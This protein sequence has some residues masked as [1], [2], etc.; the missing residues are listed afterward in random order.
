M[1]RVKRDDVDDD[2]GDDGTGR[3]RLEDRILFLLFSIC[4]ELFSFPPL[5]L[6]NVP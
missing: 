5:H 1:R 6:L 2:E 4:I 3:Q